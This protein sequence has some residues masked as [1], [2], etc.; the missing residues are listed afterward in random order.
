MLRMASQ[1]GPVCL[2]DLWMSV[3]VLCKHTSVGAML[4]HSKRESLE[5][6]PCKPAIESARNRSHVPDKCPASV[7]DEVGISTNKSTP[8]D[9]PMAVDELGSAVDDSISA[10]R[11]GPLQN[12]GSEGI[13]HDDSGPMTA[14]VGL[15][16]VSM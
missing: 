11:Q 10:K 14:I 6:N 9:R 2:D 1:A 16:G 12:W 8:Y 3:Q 4:A 5:A 13:V 7:L 15:A